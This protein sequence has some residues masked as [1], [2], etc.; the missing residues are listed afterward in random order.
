VNSVA[1]TAETQKELLEHLAEIAK[2]PAVKFAFSP[3]IDVLVN[4]ATFDRRRIV[5]GYGEILKYTPVV[6]N[7]IHEMRLVH[8]G[9]TMLA[10]HVTRACLVRTQGSIA[11]SSQKSP[12]PIEL[13]RTMI[14]SATLA[15]QNRVTQKPSLVIVPN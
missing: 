4:S 14:W 8:T 11:V 1:F 9:E 13:C 6:K 3:T 5:V 15:S 12:G 7:M 10:E 2:D